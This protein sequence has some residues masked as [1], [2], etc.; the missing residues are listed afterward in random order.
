MSSP[1]LK[2][3][4]CKQR[5]TFKKAGVPFWYP[6]FL[7]ANIG[8]ILLIFNLTRKRFV[9]QFGREPRPFLKLSNRHFLFQIPR[10]MRFIGAVVGLPHRIVLALVAV[11]PP[12][13]D[14][15]AGLVGVIGKRTVAVGIVSSA[16]YQKEFS[17]VLALVRKK[18]V[19]RSIEKIVVQK[20]A[21]V[22][23]S[24]LL[25]EH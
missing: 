11:T 17:A 5:N 13:A 12:R 16:V 8:V 23:E 15:A 9:A 25:A 21:D 22:G 24:N 19:L 1:S 6:S 18:I 2:L 14:I 20:R 3:S 4:H 7:P 10:V